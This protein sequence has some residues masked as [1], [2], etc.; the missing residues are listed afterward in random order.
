M[1]NTQQI[2]IDYYVAKYSKEKL[3]LNVFLCCEAMG[4]LQAVNVLFP[5]QLWVLECTKVV[6]ERIDTL[7]KEIHDK[8][9]I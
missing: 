9:V 8:G 2:L 3:Q 7:F 5:N 4:F 6:T 1:E